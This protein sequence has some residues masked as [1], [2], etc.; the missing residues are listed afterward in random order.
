MENSALQ[1]QL[2]KLLNV[3]TLLLN[4][5]GKNQGIDLILSSRLSF[6]VSAGQIRWIPK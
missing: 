2:Q 6:C 3:Y 4:T 1:L 5:G